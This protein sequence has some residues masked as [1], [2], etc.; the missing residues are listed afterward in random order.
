[1]SCRVCCSSHS[2]PNHQTHS[3]STTSRP[4]PSRK[5]TEIIFFVLSRHNTL[6]PRAQ[7]K[8]LIRLYLSLL[9]IVY[10][11]IHMYIEYRESR[12]RIFRVVILFIIYHDFNDDYY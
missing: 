11:S 12:T 10:N 6:A 5:Q 7:T 3:A 1:M 8:A 2:Q 4:S 9:H